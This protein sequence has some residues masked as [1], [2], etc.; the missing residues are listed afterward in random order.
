MGSHT[1]NEF[2]C[3]KYGLIIQGQNVI[4]LTVLMSCILTGA[5][6]QSTPITH[7]SRSIETSTASSRAPHSTTSQMDRS[8]TSAATTILSNLAAA[9]ASTRT[10]TVTATSTATSPTSTKRGIS[11]SRGRNLCIHIHLTILI[12][13]SLISNNRLSRSENLVPA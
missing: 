2:K 8:S 7:N 12:S 5:F 4:V 13:T 1:Q 9:A 6:G 3:R 10:S 11:T